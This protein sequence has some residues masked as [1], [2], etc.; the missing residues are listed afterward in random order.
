MCTEGQEVARFIHMHM[1]FLQ[2]HIDLVY[3]YN[4]VLWLQQSCFGSSNIVFQRCIGVYC[5]VH[6]RLYTS[7]YVYVKNHYDEKSDDC[8]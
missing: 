7:L 4:T 8:F 2:I 5:S 3:L 1:F 6:C